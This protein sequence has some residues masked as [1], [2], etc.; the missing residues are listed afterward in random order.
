MGALGEESPLLCQP[1]NSLYTKKGEI[2]MENKL[3]KWLFAFW[4]LLAIVCFIGAFF[5]PVFWVKLFGIIFGVEN[6]LIIISLL[7]TQ[8]QALITRR[9]YKKLEEK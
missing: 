2:N 9:E 4:C 5:T 3:S 7:A 6:S 8:I 1:K